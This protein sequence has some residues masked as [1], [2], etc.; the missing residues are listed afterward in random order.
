MKDLCGEARNE[1]Q[2]LIRVEWGESLQGGQSLHK[3]LKLNF[4]TVK[5]KLLYLNNASYAMHEN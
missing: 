1:T 5:Y 4:L 3:I 2:C